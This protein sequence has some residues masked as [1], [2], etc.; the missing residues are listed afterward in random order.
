[1]SHVATAGATAFVI[2]LALVASTS[3]GGTRHE[4]WSAG[5]DV[6]VATAPNLRP[7]PDRQQRP[8]VL[9]T[10]AHGYAE[11][12]ERHS[13]LTFI[14]HALGSTRAALEA[15]C[16]Y[17]ADLVLVQGAPDDLDLPC[18]ELVASRSFHGGGSAL[19]GRLGEVLPR[20]PDA[21]DS[22]ILAAVEGG[23]YP[24]WL[25]A[26]YPGARIS[27]VP[28]VHAALAAVETGAADA[29]IGLEAGLR[30]ALRRDFHATL[31]LH[32]LDS[33]F[34]DAFH[35]LARRDDQA[36]LDRIEAALVAIT[37]E[38]HA[39]L[40]QRWARQAL[41]GAL[42]RAL[43]DPAASM[44][45]WLPFV[46]LPGVGVFALLR[47]KQRRQRARA[48]KQSQAHT[49]GIVNH[50]VRNSAQTMM[51]AIDLL[52]QSS[53]P[54]GARELV[55]A[56]ASAGHSLRS[57]LNRALELSRLASGRFQPSPRP[58][59]ADHLC[60]QVLQAFSPD[61]KQ[62]GLS[63]RLTLPTEPMPP[64]RVDDQ[65]LRQILDN[66]VGN[67]LKF[68]DVGGI[69]L[70]AQLDQGAKP[71]RLMIEV[72]D[73]GI[74]ITPQ[75]LAELF[76]P[77]QQADGGRQRGG[78][79][80]GLSICRQLAR[81]MGGTLDVH[82]VH[83]RGSRFILRLPVQVLDATALDIA[84]AT[85]G[86]PQALTGLQ[87]LLVE[88]HALNRQ[89]IAGQLRQLGAEVCE[90]D[91]AASAL[92]LQAISPA[93]LVLLDIELGDSNGYTLAEGMRRQERAGTPPSLLVALSAHTDHTHL[94]RCRR[95]GIDHV[96]IKPLQIEQL[97][98]VLG[99]VTEEFDTI[100]RNV[101]PPAELQAQLG[102]EYDKDIRAGLVQLQRAIN[103]RDAEGLRH[104]A[105]RLQGVLQ[106]RGV[107]AMQ[108]VAGDLW[109]VGN[110]AAPD[111]ADA[112]R[113]LRV[114]RV[115]RGDSRPAAAPVA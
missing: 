95:A 86:L 99:K 37:I 32:S 44:L 5:R 112:E 29:A 51:T 34:P 96:L 115:W 10:L 106:M 19:V 17:Q 100:I 87:V 97:L 53:L 73:S 102:G 15:V 41:P 108:E 103:A 59:A 30:P 111:W 79:G 77:Y 26:R 42:D 46:L 71:A 2:A 38:E 18:P 40:L 50:E 85:A 93:A 39:G 104:H 63:L 101:L 12:V 57:L 78:S 1:M 36:L 68:T 58:C 54:A 91:D 6:R 83:G 74:G 13:G 98:K 31:Q 28:N 56:A 4:R 69:E 76:H 52:K 80:L 109:C 8:E 60:A 27:P 3:T 64:L 67:A 7:L 81:A 16:S 88:D 48:L 43:D 94:Q 49:A 11:L 65:C 105:H 21:F 25:T 92:A 61:A 107:A 66:L 75:Q 33:E 55:G 22:L 62:K 90:A 110:A 70:R 89:M 72:I 113:L 35:L 114:L 14:E 20:D 45:P 47:R 24:D 82:S 23:P 9:P 84:C